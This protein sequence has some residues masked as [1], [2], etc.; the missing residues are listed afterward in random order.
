MGMRETRHGLPMV[1]GL[2]IIQRPRDFRS[3][4]ERD[5]HHHGAMHRCQRTQSCVEACPVDCI[6]TGSAD[7]TSTTSTLIDP[8]VCIECG[9]CEPVCP[10]SAI[11]QDSDVPDEW[12]HYTQINADFFKRY[13]LR[14]LK[15]RP[16]GS[17]AE[18][19]CFVAARASAG[20]ARPKP[21]E[22]SLLARRSRTAWRPQSPRPRYCP[23]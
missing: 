4:C 13:K 12:K 18:R 20:A 7:L 3:E 17:T 9:A 21:R 6:H 2:P 22:P 5:V 8:D 19:S 14:G 15:R 10:V 11:R 1:H 16:L 23:V